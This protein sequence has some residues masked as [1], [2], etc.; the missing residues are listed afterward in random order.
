M[1]PS[2]PKNCAVS[3][4]W[5]VSER[6]WVSAHSLTHESRNLQKAAHA[7][8]RR[9]KIYMGSHSL[10]HAHSRRD[11]C[12]SGGFFWI[13][14]SFFLG[15]IARLPGNLEMSFSTGKEK[16]QSRSRM[17]DVT[18]PDTWIIPLFDSATFLIQ[19]TVNMADNRGKKRKLNPEKICSWRA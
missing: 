8:S 15:K 12:V 3:E 5:A 11:W 2:V 10:T 19:I 4:R 9:R 6:E 13:S 17:T 7:H 1:Q 16:H 18:S 14:R